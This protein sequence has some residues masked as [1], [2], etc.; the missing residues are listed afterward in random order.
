[1]TIPTGRAT[2]D[3]PLAGHFHCSARERAAF[4]AGIKLGSALHQYSGTPFRRA[5]APT[6]E[7]AI[8]ASI[9]SQP[10]VVDAKATIVLPRPTGDGEY[11]Y[12][13]VDQHNLRLDVL[14][15]YMGVQVRGRIEYL[16][17]RAYPLMTL[18]EIPSGSSSL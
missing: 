18:H 17:D 14:I 10:Y 13:V 2:K 12:H 3:D 6:I 7:A 1:M 5:A 15:D 9:R 8:A 11:D 4:E 16:D